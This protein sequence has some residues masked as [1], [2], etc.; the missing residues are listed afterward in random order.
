MVIDV[1]FTGNGV[2]PTIFN[3]CDGTEITSRCKTAIAG[4]RG[5]LLLNFIVLIG[6]YN[7]LSEST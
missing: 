7:L 1:S 4:L 2:I 3:D 5:S 6:I